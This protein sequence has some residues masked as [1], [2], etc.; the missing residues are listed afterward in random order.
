M[1]KTDYTTQIEQA[2]DKIRDEGRYRT[3]HDVC[4]IST[5]FP[6][7]WW[8]DANGQ[9]KQI[10][11]WCSNDYLGMGQHPAVL[12][13]MHTALDTAGAGSGGTR[14]IGGST[15]YHKE[16]EVELADLHNKPAALL[17]TSAFNANEAALSALSRLLPGLI[18]FSDAL[19]HASMIAGISH[20]KAEK[21]IFAHNDIA[22]LRRLLETAPKDAPKLIA[23]E[24]L[25]SM[26]GDFA[27]IAE[28]C[29]LADE[30]NAMTYVDEVHA[31]GMYGATG[32]G[33]FGTFGLGTSRGYYQWDTGES[34]RCYG[35]IYRGGRGVSGCRALFR[36]R[37]YFHNLPTTSRGERG[38]CFGS[39]GEGTSRIAGG[40]SRC[41][42]RVKG[43]VSR[44]GF[45]VSGLWQ[46]YCACSYRQSSQVQNAVGCVVK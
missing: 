31:V 11:I 1:Q 13:A 6:R 15:I 19:N 33:V 41:C 17:F 25:Y 8:Q 26:D 21:H 4:R 34:L 7:A 44:V 12:D 18:V 32:A 10:T 39:L 2:L 27:P 5:D 35:R 45:A 42:D 40:A 28:I 23:F 30:F 37:V 20:G 3:F 29:D 43:T 24:S 16:L 14:N 9:R 38:L 46:S 36:A 22:D